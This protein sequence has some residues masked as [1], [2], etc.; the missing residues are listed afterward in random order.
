M[1]GEAMLHFEGDKDL[2]KPPSEIFGLLGDARFLVQCIPGGQPVG[3]PDEDRAVC[4]VRPALA[5][6]TGSLEVTVKVVERVPESR[7]RVTLHSKGIGTSSD[8]ETALTLTPQEGGTQLHWV[9]DVTRLG[10][11][12]KAVPSGLIRGAA[13]KVITEVWDNVEAKLK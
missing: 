8:V 5:F 11:L 1:K 10:G 6:V 9:A 13:Q 12:L 4:K 2:P 7:V 3:E